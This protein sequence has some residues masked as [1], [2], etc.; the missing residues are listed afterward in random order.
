MDKIKVFFCGIFGSIGGLVIQALGGWSTDFN[1]LFVFMIIDFMLGLA[2]GFIFKKSSKTE[3][4]AGDSNAMFK[5][6][7]KKATYL[8]IVFVAYRLDLTLKLDYI[9]TATILAL[10]LNEAISIIENAGLMGAPIPKVLT[11]AIDVLKKKTESES[12]I[13]E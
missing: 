7:C 4:G 8:V 11:N 3:T 9:R 1:T 12:D 13:N 10:I 6:L 2:L 5:G